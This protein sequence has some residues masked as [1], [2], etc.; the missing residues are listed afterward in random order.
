[1]KVK[2]AIYLSLIVF[3]SQILVSCGH[4]EKP[5]VAQL[6]QG[7]VEYGGVFRINEVGDVRSLYP[8]N[9][10]EVAGYRIANQVY[11]GLVKYDQATLQPR[12]ALAESWETNKDATEWT[13]HLRQ[14]VLF[15]D[16]PCFEDGVGRNVVAEDVV[17]CIKQLCTPKADNS[18]FW[19]AANR[20]KG[21]RAYSESQ[22]TDHP[23]EEIEGVELIDEYTIKI[24]LSF[25]N[26]GFLNILGHNGFYVFPKEAQ[27][28]YGQEFGVNPVGTGP[29]RIKAFK[30]N[31]IAVLERNPNYYQKDEFG[32]KLPYLD[33]IEISFV[34]DKKA[35]LLNFKKGQLDMIFTLPIEM[36][37]DVMSDLS[38]AKNGANINFKPQ[39]MPSL[40]VHFYAFKHQN[41]VFSDVKVRKA[42]NM[43][44]DRESLVNY[45][46]QG[47]GSPAIYG[48]VPPAFSG[49]DYKQIKGFTF[50]P[51]AARELLSEAGFPNG[52]GF[53][54]LTLEISSGGSNYELIA[55]VIQNM[56]QQNLNIKINIEVLPM[57]QQLD[58]AEGGKAAFWRNGWVADYPDP[59]NFLC[60]FVGADLPDANNG[61]AYMNSGR[62]LNPAY[63]S[64]YLQAIKELDEEKRQKLYRELDQILIND[65]VILPIYYDEFTRLIPVYV[66]NFPQNSIEYRDFSAV[67][68]KSALREN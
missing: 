34:K 63:D 15:H 7:G 48:F 18:M 28:Y 20:I 33:A 24:S 29:F 54:E 35:E 53:P 31:E 66:M 47:E 68:F 1:M 44:V 17:W 37:A 57:G 14:D 58:N 12:P 13:F 67:W 49:Y 32:N 61:R 39:V 2:F 5:K 19:V 36:Y 16:D 11:E 59:E 60:Y 56:L 65:A 6:A 38:E 30:P 26:A 50:D 52:V 42:F 43:A 21:A 46:L 22:D 27:E 3:S 23:L 4:E 9:I 8:L 25:P 51:M 40:S 55:Q 10:T 45:T 64:L 41:E 62:Y